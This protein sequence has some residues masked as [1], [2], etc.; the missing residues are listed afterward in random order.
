[1]PCDAGHLLYAVAR[2]KQSARALVAHVV[3]MQI[4]NAVFVARTFKIFADRLRMNWENAIINARLPNQH[5]LRIRSQRYALIV[6]YFFSGVFSVA[7]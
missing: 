6:A 2:L 5:L 1:M 4:D 3:Q 7:H